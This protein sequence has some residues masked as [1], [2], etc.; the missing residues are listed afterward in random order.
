[1]IEF[2]PFSKTLL[3]ASIFVLASDGLKPSGRTMLSLKMALKR[4]SSRHGNTL[5]AW[6]DWNC[7]DA[8]HLHTKKKIGKKKSKVSITRATRDC[9]TNSNTRRRM[10]LLGGVV[11]RIFT[12]IKSMHIRL[13]FAGIREL[14]TIRFSFPQ[15][16]LQR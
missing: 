9:Q 14:Q 11:F 3:V 4:G 6:C 16:I 10:Y 8:N 7:V 15:R 2:Y 1:M 13:Q 12:T 5:R